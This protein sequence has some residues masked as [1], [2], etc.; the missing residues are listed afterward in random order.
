MD[1]NSLVLGSFDLEVHAS[2]KYILKKMGLSKKVIDMM[3]EKCPGQFK[4]IVFEKMIAYIEKIHQDWCILPRHITITK[5]PRKKG[6]KHDTF[7]MHGAHTYDRTLRAP[8]KLSEY[9]ESVPE[10]LFKSMVKF[11][12]HRRIRRS[13]LKELG[14]EY[15][16]APLI[17]R[18]DPV[19]FV[20]I[21]GMKELTF[22][23]G[24]WE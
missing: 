11:E 12:N 24:E 13:G 4:H 20:Q 17:G 7:Q 10:R 3:E 1:N 2:V 5:N 6:L 16:V 14:F 22:Y 19:L 18:R 9:P 21:G 23:L 8:V 15:Y